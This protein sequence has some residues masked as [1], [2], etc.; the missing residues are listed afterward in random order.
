MNG[1]GARLGAMKLS[2]SGYEG[3]LDSRAAE[4]SLY[5]LLI[6]F[7][8]LSGP[9]RVL[10]GQGSRVFTL[11]LTIVGLLMALYALL[12]VRK[13]RLVRLIFYLT[14][15][16]T[17]WIVVTSLLGGIP[18][19]GIAAGMSILAFFPAVLSLGARTPLGDKGQAKTGVVGALL[20][21]N[22]SV[23]GVQ[24]FLMTGVDRGS[25]LLGNDR[26]SNTIALFTMLVSLAFW[27]RDSRL[28]SPGLWLFVLASVLA[29]L[30]DSKASLALVFTL[31]TVWIVVVAVTRTTDRLS[32][33]SLKKLAPASLLLGA[34][35]ALG[36]QGILTGAPADLGPEV[37]KGVQQ[38]YVPGS[39]NPEDQ[40]TPA[41]V[42]F[43]T[44]V[45]GRMTGEGLG[46]GG[47]YL[48]V[49][50]TQGAFSF[51]PGSE[52]MVERHI[53]KLAN[54]KFDTSKWGLLYSPNKTFVGV[55]D[56][57]GLV[58]LVLYGALLIVTL[59]QFRERVQTAVMISIGCMLFVA[60]VVTPFLEYPEVALSVTAFLLLL[61]TGDMPASVPQP[62]KSL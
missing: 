10:F 39:D 53:E 25:G 48:G 24:V 1:D 9:S 12:R 56:E 45:A 22:L 42:D 41:T 33:C 35:L 28:W 49:L 57:L 15:V 19:W 47:S 2:P 16:N 59:L 3:K 30:G 50:T 43:T 38:L 32:R 14:L 26:A 58:G 27:L 21:A 61:A 52:I 17:I 46:S 31:V 29:W 13:L 44:D 34:L 5:A 18:L 36:V 23:L 37:R 4:I 8:A 54:R 51:L 20:I 40:T 11:L 55:I 6:W 62:A 60:G 7:F